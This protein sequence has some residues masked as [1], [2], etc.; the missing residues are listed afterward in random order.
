MGVLYLVFSHHY[1][2]Y[3]FNLGDISCYEKDGQS[4]GGPQDL[5]AAWIRTPAG[6]QMECKPSGYDGRGFAYYFDAARNSGIANF[7]FTATNPKFIGYPVSFPGF[8]NKSVS[9]AR[10]E[11]D[12]YRFGIPTPFTKI[13]ICNHVEV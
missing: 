12:W 7:V 11:S 6:V 4:S 1:C 8:G 13:G 10:I 9:P 5:F 2:W 3:D